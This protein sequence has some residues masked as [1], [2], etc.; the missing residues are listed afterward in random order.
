MKNKIYALLIVI[1]ITIFNL[2]IVVFQTPNG[3]LG[4]LL[5]LFSTLTIILTSIKLFQNSKRFQ[6]FIKIILEML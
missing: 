5:C 1:G 4:Y 2:Q 6:E 3:F